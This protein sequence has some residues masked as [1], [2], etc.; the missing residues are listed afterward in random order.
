MLDKY[1]T[2][3]EALERGKATI[4]RFPDGP[5]GHGLS[6]KPASV[7]LSNGYSCN[8][9][10]FLNYTAN[11]VRLPLKKKEEAVHE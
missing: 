7:T 10:P 11:P 3:K 6:V 2:Y 9:R 5:S 4:T 8:R 1:E